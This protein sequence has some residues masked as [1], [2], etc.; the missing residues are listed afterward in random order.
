MLQRFEVLGGYRL[1]LF[2]AEKRRAGCACSESNAVV[3]QLES[4][5]QA[6]RLRRDAQVVRVVTV[7]VGNEAVEDSRSPLLWFLELAQVGAA[8][9][10]WPDDLNARLGHSSTDLGWHFPEDSC[11]NK[12]GPK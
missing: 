2:G 4:R 7:A 1:A 12:V 8:V 9:V 6:G 5:L 3:D 10:A 11:R